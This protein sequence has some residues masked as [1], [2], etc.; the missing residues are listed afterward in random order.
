[1]A[2]PRRAAREATPQELD[3]G[4]EVTPQVEREADIAAQQHGDALFDAMLNVTPE[5]DYSPREVGRVHG[6]ASSA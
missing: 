2:N 5:G 1:M 3:A 4:A 6:K